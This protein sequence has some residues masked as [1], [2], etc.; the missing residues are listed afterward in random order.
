ML[1]TMVEKTFSCAIGRWEDYEVQ[2]LFW[3]MEGRDIRSC[4]CGRRYKRIK[5]AFK[6]F[7]RAGHSPTVAAS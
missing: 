2:Y 3:R 4:Q 6:H 5:W 1:Q 7:V